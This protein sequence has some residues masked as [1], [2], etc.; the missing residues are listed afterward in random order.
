M[1]DT[2]AHYGSLTT[3]SKANVLPL[4]VLEHADA[5]SKTKMNQLLYHLHRRASVYARMLSLT[6]AALES[7][8]STIGLCTNDYAEQMSRSIGELA[9]K[10]ESLHDNCQ[11]LLNLHLSL[12]SF[13]TNELM[14][15]LTIFSAFFIPLTFI[16][17][18][19]GMNFVNMPELQ[20]KYGYF[21]CLAGMF[22]ITIGV[23][24]FFRLKGLV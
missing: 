22:V 21:Y 6:Q 8:Y 18:V 5:L 23:F 24:I 16:C 11:N 1:I 17:G 4:L 19:Y 7:A 20:L 10:A 13:R 14:N 12:V 2:S 15:I 3:R 9:V